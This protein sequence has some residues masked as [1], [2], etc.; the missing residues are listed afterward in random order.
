MGALSAAAKLAAAAKKAA[1]AP[2]F[3]VQRLA[4]KAPA[5][6]AKKP[7]V[8]KALGAFKTT[9]PGR[10]ISKT[11]TKGGYSV[12]LPTGKVRNYVAVSP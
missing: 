11:N 5:P 12:N 1:A 3:A 10:I 7:A 9:T 6:A 8:K 2:S 4:A